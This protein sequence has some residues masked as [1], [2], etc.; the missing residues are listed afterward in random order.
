MRSGSI[1]ASNRIVVLHNPAPDGPVLGY[2]DGKPIA[3]AVIDE[4]GRRYV[5]AG[6][7]PRR[8]DGRIDEASLQR[9]EWL[10]ESGLIY[11]WDSQGRRK[12]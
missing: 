10:T 8:R 1:L 11:R 5:Y 12:H 2:Y 7:G 9:G 6:V 3:S 4:F